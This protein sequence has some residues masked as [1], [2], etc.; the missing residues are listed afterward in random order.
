MSIILS[1]FIKKKILVWKA[2]FLDKHEKDDSVLIHWLKFID[3]NMTLS[4]FFLEFYSRK[5]VWLSVD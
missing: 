5:R 3:W 1:L 4:D 2:P